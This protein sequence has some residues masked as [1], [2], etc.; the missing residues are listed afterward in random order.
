MGVRE[1]ESSEVGGW[2]ED[3][4]YA[5]FHPWSDGL[6]RCGRC[7]DPDRDPCMDIDDS[8]WGILLQRNDD[9]SITRA[10]EDHYDEQT[11]GWS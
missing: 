8:S 6:L 4:R 2:E 9:G 1:I 10:F 3:E 7:N 11:G 5:I